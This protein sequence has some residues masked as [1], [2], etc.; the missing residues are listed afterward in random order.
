MDKAYNRCLF[1]RQYMS[2][3]CRPGSRVIPAFSDLEK[4]NLF[5][6]SDFAALTELKKGVFN[7]REGSD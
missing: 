6:V 3:S 1:T 7:V 2:A 4:Q 5:L